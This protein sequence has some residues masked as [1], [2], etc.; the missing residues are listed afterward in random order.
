MNWLKTT[1]SPASHIE[2][3]E[4][5]NQKEVESYSFDDFSII[6]KKQVYLILFNNL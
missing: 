6:R 4:F 2:K 3:V 1:G 5:K